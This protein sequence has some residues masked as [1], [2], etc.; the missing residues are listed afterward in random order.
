MTYD[1]TPHTHTGAEPVCAQKSWGGLLLAG[2]SS[3]GAVCV[4]HNPYPRRAG[5]LQVHTH[6]HT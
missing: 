4:A 2:G 5:F 3:A 6:T 1:M